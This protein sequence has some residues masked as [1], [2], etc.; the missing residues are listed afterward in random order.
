MSDVPNNAGDTIVRNNTVYRLIRPSSPV[1]E[2]E[3]RENLAIWQG[4]DGNCCQ[5]SLDETYMIPL[6]D[7]GESLQ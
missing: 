6:P 2:I 1:P 4:P 7:C 5:L 3:G